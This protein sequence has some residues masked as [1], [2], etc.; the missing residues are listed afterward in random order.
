MNTELEKIFSFPSI[1]VGADTGPWVNRYEA[2]LDMRVATS[3]SSDYNIAYERVKFWFHDV[4]HSAVL[5]HQEDPKLQT[6]RDTGMSC[7]DFP[8]NPVDQIVG[9]MLMSKL[10]AITEGRLEIL[11]VGIT[12]PSDD[13]VTYFCD[14][15]DHLHWFEEPGWWRDPRP[16]YCTQ[17]RRSRGHGKVISINRD[18]DWKDHDLDWPGADN[19][20][21]NVSVLPVRAPDAPE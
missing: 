17:P 20:V 7:L 10:T 12:S 14:R 6:W 5:I 4:M 21:G 3:L 18:A 8:Q 15:E 9:L 13:H 1:L 11:R 2:K 16:I 19:N